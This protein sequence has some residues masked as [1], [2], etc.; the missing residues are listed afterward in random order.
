MQE[1]YQQSDHED[2]DNQLWFAPDFASSAIQDGLCI[3]TTQQYGWSK[4]AGGISIPATEAVEKK[5]AL[6]EVISIGKK[7]D[8]TEVAVGDI[9]TYQRAT[10]FRLPRGFLP[11]IRFRLRHDATHIQQCHPN[12]VP[13]KI[14]AHWLSKMKNWT[15][16]NWYYYLVMAASYALRDRQ[17]PDFDGMKPLVEEELK[18]LLDEQ[19]HEA[20]GFLFSALEG[21]LCP[22]GPT[23]PTGSAQIG[24]L[25]ESFKT[26][27]T[28]KTLREADELQRDREIADQVRQEIRN[29]RS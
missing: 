2:I 14:S 8:D 26:A 10:A 18:P 11:P 15:G 20:S 27:F 22:T 19:P 28:K 1:Q 21:P 6:G 12:L 25:I 13:S 3:E 7:V 24:V 5:Y 4:S 17:V 23:G 29:G 16:E 9:I